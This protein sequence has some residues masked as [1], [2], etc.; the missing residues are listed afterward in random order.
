MA[1]EYR[2]YRSAASGGPIDYSTPIATTALLTANDSPG[3]GTWSYGV[4]AYDTA[5]AIEE[6]NT[7]ARVTLVISGGL[8]VS[9]VPPGPVGITARPGAGGTC[10]V[11]WSYPFPDPSPRPTGFKVWLTAGAA[12]NYAAA[13]AAT[14][15]YGG[16]RPHSADLSGLADGVAYSIGVRAYTPARDDRNTLRATAVGDTSAPADVEDLA[17]SAVSYQGDP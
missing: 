14:V 9:A 3:D 6:D 16:P 2:V 1:I 5:S 7:D 12:V 17:I 4:R 11:D 10:R 8:D 15:A 13:P